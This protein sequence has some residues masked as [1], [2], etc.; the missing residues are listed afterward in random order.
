MCV[1]Y[2]AARNA[3]RQLSRH[4]WSL[5]ADEAVSGGLG[6]GDLQ[7]DAEMDRAWAAS[8]LARAWDD[9]RAWAADGDLETEGVAL[10]ERHLEGIPL[11]RAA[12]E[13]GLS[14]GTAHRRLAKARHRL[15][16]AVIAHLRFADD[17]GSGEEDEDRAYSLLIDAAR[18]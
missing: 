1:A 14:L 6:A 8:V 4:D 7:P 18:A 5:V 15:R 17:P 13:L 2:N 9:L 10:L 12:E 3:R 11:R 16:W